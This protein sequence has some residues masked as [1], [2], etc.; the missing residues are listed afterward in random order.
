MRHHSFLKRGTLA[1]HWGPLWVV[2]LVGWND[3]EVFSE[4]C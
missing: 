4:L 3:S 1:K 2:F